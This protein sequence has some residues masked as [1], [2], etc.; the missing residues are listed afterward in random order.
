MDIA[1]PEEEVR[2]R[3]IKDISSCY[4][5]EFC[6]CAVEHYEGQAEEVRGRLTKLPLFLLSKLFR[7]LSIAIIRVSEAASAIPLP[8]R[9]RHARGIDWCI[10]GGS[11]A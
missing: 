6:H 7:F 4:C 9:L 11:A 3:P 8:V 1:F 5:T 2:V 10:H